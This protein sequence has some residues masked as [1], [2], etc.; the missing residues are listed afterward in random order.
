VASAEL[1]LLFYP[2]QVGTTLLCSQSSSHVRALMTND[3]GDMPGLYPLS[4][5]NNML[6][7]WR[8]CQRVQDLGEA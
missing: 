1:L 7:H 8:A 4:G 3:H 2:N 6:N 5:F